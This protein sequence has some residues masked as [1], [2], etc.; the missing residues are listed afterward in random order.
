MEEKSDHSSTLLYQHHDDEAERIL[1]VLSHTHTTTSRVYV[2]SQLLWTGKRVKL[3]EE[4]F[5][6]LVMCLHVWSLFQP[7]HM[8]GI[9]SRAF[10]KHRRAF[11][12]NI[13][14]FD[15]AS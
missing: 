3:M 1:L 4:I 7:V 14:Y 8:E 15:L 11:S 10:C 12:S 6:A 9:G 13:K 2:F 5:V